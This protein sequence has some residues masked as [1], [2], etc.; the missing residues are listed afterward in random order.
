LILRAKALVVE[1]SQKGLAAD[2][3]LLATTRIFRGTDELPLFKDLS[4][5]NGSVK[6]WEYLEQIRGDDLQLSL[7]LAGKISTSKDHQRVV[8]ESQSV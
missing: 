1:P 2:G 5:Y 6:V 4:Y 8:L 7:L 3:P